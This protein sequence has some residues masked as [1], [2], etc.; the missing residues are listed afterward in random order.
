MNRNLVYR[1][2]ANAVRLNAGAAL[3][4]AL[5]LALC[6]VPAAVRA[7][8]PGPLELVETLDLERYQGRWYE[9]AL[10]PNRFQDRCVAETAAEYTLLE[11]GRVQV[12]NRCRTAD[13]NLAQ[14]VGA[15]RRP[16]PERPA[17]L[18]VRFA[19]RWL[20]WLPLVW[21][22]YQVM[23]IDADYSSALVGEPSRE[24]L[25]VLAR[26]P[27][28]PEARLQ[29]LLSEGRRQGFDTDAVVMS[30]QEPQ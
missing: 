28:L 17:Q 23:M 14:V 13:G 6:F 21:G 4:T 9:I 15:A 24:F 8:R 3:L 30:R 12:V 29:E 19:P 2:P 20:S 27:S 7:D 10:L 5:L 26:E 25:W 16:D 1:R 22:D 18:E 11:S